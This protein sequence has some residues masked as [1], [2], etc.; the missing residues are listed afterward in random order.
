MSG[1]QK[2][3]K[4]GKQRRSKS[5]SP[6][7]GTS[8]QSKTAQ[9][10]IGGGFYAEP[11]NEYKKRPSGRGTMTT[12]NIAVAGVGNANAQPY[13]TNWRTVDTSK[14][15]LQLVD[16]ILDNLAIYQDLMTGQ[17]IF[18]ERNPLLNGYPT[19]KE[20]GLYTPYDKTQTK[21]AL[22]QLWHRRNRV[23]AGPAFTADLAFEYMAEVHEYNR[24]EKE[25]EEIKY[26]KYVEPLERKE[27]ERA[28]EEHKKKSEEMKRIE[29]RRED[30]FLE[31]LRT[32][33]QI[34]DI[35]KSYAKELKLFND[36]KRDTEP[37]FPDN[38]VNKLRAKIKDLDKE[39]RILNGE[40]IPD[41]EPSTSKKTEPKSVKKWPKVIAE[42][43]LS[44]SSRATRASNA[45][46]NTGRR[47]SQSPPV[48]ATSRSRS[49]S[50]S[51]ERTGKGKGKGKGKAPAKTTAGSKKVSKRKSRKRKQSS[52]KRRSSKK[53]NSRKP[54]RKS[55]KNKISKRKK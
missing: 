21:E 44:T 48:N 54:K 33:E 30:L 8:R 17:L 29:K 46:R 26:K 34:K 25:S 16:E 28:R 36:E 14:K 18:V 13:K 40:K 24:K 32:E 55:S 7:S 51:Q 41:K 20:M 42:P 2:T 11:Y 27:K 4:S 3:K 5:S 37:L 50:R 9:L 1:Q 19:D 15:Q 35:A 49:R 12:R 38:Q 6:T 45:Y 39:I 52:S 10:P 22:K 43:Q 53:K 47:M 23:N 31:I